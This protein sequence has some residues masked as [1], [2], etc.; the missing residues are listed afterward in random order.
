[1]SIKIITDSTSN[2]PESLLKEYDVS[3][4]SLSVVFND[5]V[6]KEVEISNED[7]Y[8]KLKESKEMPTSSQPSIEE[9]YNIFEQS[10]IEKQ[11][12]IGVFISSDMS[13]TFSTAHLA[14]NM[15]IEKYPDAKIELLDSRSNCMQLGYAALI[16]CRL[17]KEGKSFSDVVEGVKD[18]IKRSKFVFIPDTLE[19]LK[20]GGRIGSAGALLGSILQI[21]PI[22]TVADGK[23][24]VLGKVRTKKR[25]IEKMVDLLIKDI[26][27]F[28]LGEVIIH[29]IN[30]E[31]E[32]KKL[33]EYIGDK[34]EQV[35]S[36]C[37]IGPVI[38][39]HVGPGTV[40]IAY[41]T[42]NDLR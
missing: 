11:D 27:E 25:A 20:K 40:G 2:I 12:I 39:V 9:F 31:E 7:F 28:G 26:Q 35:I 1:M 41:Y 17:A 33:A 8:K 37:P 38:G 29:H 24:D 32:A 15:V 23:T 10:I 3:V 30:C 16:A 5:E 18:N 36:V 22:L 6:Y 4:V 14:K 19:Y 13:G 42:K 34:I 21:K